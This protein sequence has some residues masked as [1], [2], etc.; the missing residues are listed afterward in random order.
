MMDDVI[1]I[2]GD[3]KKKERLKRNWG[4]RHAQSDKKKEK[5]EL[6]AHTTSTFYLLKTPPPHHL[7]IFTLLNTNPIQSFNR[8]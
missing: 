7:S 3:N 8:N 4:P 1:L 5:G 6:E 2:E